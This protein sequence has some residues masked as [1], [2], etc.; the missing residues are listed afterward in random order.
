MHKRGFDGGGHDGVVE[1]NMV[2]CVES[3]VGDPYGG[4]GVKLEE[5]ILVTANGPV[6]LSSYVYEEQLL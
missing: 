1:E 2:F 3:F 4:E 5:Q 6:K